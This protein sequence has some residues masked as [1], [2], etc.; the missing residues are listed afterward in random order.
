MPGALCYYDIRLPL[1]Y[2]ILRSPFDVMKNYQICNFQMNYHL[3]ADDTVDLHQS[4]VKY[5]RETKDED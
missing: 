2:V 1:Y 3:G 4:D 5:Q